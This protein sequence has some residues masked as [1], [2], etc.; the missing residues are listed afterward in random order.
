[1]C[2]NYNNEAEFYLHTK[3]NH[4]VLIELPYRVAVP[5]KPFEKKEQNLWVMTLMLVVA[6]ISLSDH[7]YCDFGD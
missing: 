6:K 4:I 5:L 1:M 3:L 7:L 2:T